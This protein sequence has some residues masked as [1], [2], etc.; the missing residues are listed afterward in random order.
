[1]PVR[2]F[3]ASW[4]LRERKQREKFQAVIHDIPEDMTMATLW[5]DRK[6]NEFLMHSGASAFKIIQTSKGRRK[7]V[8]YFE[9]WETTLKALDSPPVTLPLGKELKW[10][11][12]SI[13]NLKKARKLKTKN[14][15]DTKTSGN[16]GNAPDSNKSKKKDQAA[17]PTF[18]HSNNPDYVLVLVIWWQNSRIN[19][20]RHSDSNAN[21]LSHSRSRSKSRDRFAST[22]RRDNNNNKNNSYNNNQNKSTPNSSQHTWQRRFA[23]TACI[24]DAQDICTS[25]HNPRQTRRVFKF[26]SVTESQWSEFTDKAN[27]LCEVSPSTFSSWHINQMCEYLQSRILNATKATLPSSTVGNNYTPKVPKEL[28]TLIQQYPLTYSTAHE[29]KWSTHL[30]RLQNILQLYK[31]VFTFIPTLP[32]SLSSCRQDD[33]KSL[34]DTLSNLSKSLRRFQLLK[35]KEFQDSSIRARVEDRNNN[36]ETD[37]SSFINSVLSRNRR[38]I[39]LDHVFLDHPTR[40]Q[41][42]TDPKDIDDAVVNHFQNFVPINSTPPTSIDVLPDRWSSAYQP[43][44]DVSSSI[45]DSLMNPLLLKNVMSKF[46]FTS[47]DSGIGDP[48]TDYL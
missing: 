41:L 48:S 31:K 34:L 37:L 5:M 7:L 24:F 36:F 45:Y 25:D 46:P 12:H 44:N 1:I 27:A 30:I 26:D 21:A 32:L 15:P 22:S 13:P 33:F 19:Q 28:E 16:T 43:M 3:P 10:C 39:T 11:R 4:T 2:W 14:T 35:E 29:H 6:P 17:L 47:L 20:S 9:N 23:L 38:Y 42:L 8:G 18:V 40:P